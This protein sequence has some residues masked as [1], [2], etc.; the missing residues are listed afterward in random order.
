MN[1]RT[2]LVVDSDR[3]S[4]DALAKVLGG[5][6]YQVLTAP[7]GLGGWQVFQAHR[8]DLVILDVLLPK[9]SGFELCEKIA[10]AQGASIP[11]PVIVISEFTK[12]AG[13]MFEPL[14]AAGL[15]ATFPKPVPQKELLAALARLE[16][17]GLA[18]RQGPGQYPSPDPRAG[19]NIV[20][21]PAPG[22][23]SE[24]YRLLLAD[25]NPI[26]RQIIQR[27]FSK[28]GF[29][30]D[31]STDGYEVSRSIAKLRPDIVLLDINLPGLS[32]YEICDLIRRT[33]ILSDTVVIYLREP[34]EKI[35]LEK[36]RDCPAEGLIL[37]PIKSSEWVQ[38]VKALLDKKA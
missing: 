16:K 28:E 17:A 21:F 36:M 3:I 7:D 1:I 27:A 26:T 10:R 23:R 13:W 18:E 35:D 37:K 25:D 29:Q 22:K 8:P 38:K 31:V 11:I 2:I 4:L 33:P 34:F 12:E 19:D 5:E 14:K 15:A 24:P 6:G 32:G 20:A 9:L 30:V